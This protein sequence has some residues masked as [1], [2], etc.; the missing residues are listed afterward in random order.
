[1]KTL[2]MILIASSA[3]FS[4]IQVSGEE[5]PPKSGNDDLK[6]SFL[7]RREYLPAISKPLTSEKKIDAT[8]A[9]QY[10]AVRKISKDV[11]PENYNMP[12]K[13][14]SLENY[15]MPIKH[16]VSFDEMNADVYFKQKSTT[17]SDKKDK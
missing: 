15:S 11:S 1:M 16:G 3:A 4:Q 13:K 17:I 10:S 2:L 12:V 6:N 9:Y 5:T 7:I 8:G 14:V